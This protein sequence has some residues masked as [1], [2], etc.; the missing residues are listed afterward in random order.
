VEALGQII[1]AARERGFCFGVTDRTGEVV[2]SRYVS[3][4]RPI[5]EIADPVPYIQPLAFG[6]V[7]A[8][9]RPFTFIPS[10]LEIAATHEPA[11]F[12]RGGTARL[13]LTVS[14]RRGEPTD[15][16]R[17]RV[18]D[19]LP[20]GLIATAASGEGWTCSGTETVQCDRNDVLGPRGSY[21]PITITVSVA[22]DAPPTIVHAPT[23]S[24]HGGVWF[25]AVSDE[26]GVG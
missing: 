11:T 24:G 12:E 20:P 17:V 16:S 10:A 9:P 26:I 8:L 4:G 14:N 3:S 22:A 21:P 15:G 23:V 18:T 25:D 1:D 13:T 7:E 5:P 6:E 19:A 2:A